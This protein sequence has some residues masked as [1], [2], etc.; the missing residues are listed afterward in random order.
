GQRIVEGRAAGEAV[1]AVD[2][3]LDAGRRAGVGEPEHRVQ[4]A[5]SVRGDP[6]AGIRKDR[7]LA[8]A[9][10]RQVGREARPVVVG[11]Y[12]ALFDRVERTIEVVVGDEHLT[13]ANGDPGLVGRVHTIGRQVYAAGR[14]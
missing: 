2:D 9:A 12:D 8:A 10:D 14:P 3:V 11:T 5:G 4:V 7:E 1:E 6:G 13:A